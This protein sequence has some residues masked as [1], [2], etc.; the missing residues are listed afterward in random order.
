MIRTS[1]DT[2]TSVDK[3]WGN[4]DWVVN[5]HKYCGKILTLLPGY[6][7]SLHYHP[8][9]E[10]TFL[11]LTGLVV[12][13]I[14]P[15]GVTASGRLKNK[16]GELIYLSSNQRHAVTLKP[17]TPHRFWSA[18]ENPA[19]VAEFSTPHNDDDVVRLEESKK[20]GER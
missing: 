8:V 6:Q 12:L 9:K 5:S 4:E 18:T 7:C 3:I 19:L 16:Q 20:V 17:G 13:E 15:D 11:C 2:R 1:K 14:F 10:E